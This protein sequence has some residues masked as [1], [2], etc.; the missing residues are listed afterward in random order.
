MKRFRKDDTYHIVYENLNEFFT[1]TNPDT[2]PSTMNKYNQSQVRDMKSDNDWRYGD[3]RNKS[4]FYDVRFDPSKGKQMCA[5][6][7]KKTMADGT[8]KKLVRQAMTY[9][10]RIKFDDHGFRLNVSKAI[11]GEDKYFGIYKNSK[12]PTVKIAINICGSACVGQEEFRKVAETAIPTIYALET[13]GIAT[14][15]YYT[16]FVDGCHNDENNRDIPHTITHVKIKSA[17]E[18]FNW[19]TFAPVFCLGSY[20]ESI[21]MSWIGS[22]YSTN[23]GLG[24]PMPDY[25]IQNHD[26][27]GYTSVIGLNGVGPVKIINQVF[28]KIGKK[29]C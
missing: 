26:N 5:D 29:E 3:E 20:R 25:K 16:A 23:S 8:Y 9:R 6:A 18:R 1:E 15:V 17:Q 27:Y 19:T 2:P 13:A 12:K 7:V 21:F 24:R 14:E 28:E 11:S 22:E 4:K 10:K